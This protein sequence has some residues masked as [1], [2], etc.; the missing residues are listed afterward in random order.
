MV[1]TMKCVVAL[2]EFGWL[3]KGFTPASYSWSWHH[4][5]LNFMNYTSCVVG[6]SDST[7]G[8]TDKLC[9]ETSH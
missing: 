8:Q 7:Q 9:R 2:S 1:E 6:N 5:S 3:L 4:S